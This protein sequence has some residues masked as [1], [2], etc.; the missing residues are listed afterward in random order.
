VETEEAA[1]AA[2][3]PAARR[4]A[5]GLLWGAAQAVLLC[6]PLLAGGLAA[7]YLTQALTGRPASSTAA[8]IGA[9]AGAGAGVLVCHKARAWLLEARLRRLRADGVSARGVVRRL[10][11]QWSAGGRGGSMT[12]YAAH[13]QWRDPATGERWQGERR[14]RFYGRGSRQLEAVLAAGEQVELRYPAGRPQRFVIDVPF[15]PVMA[16]VLG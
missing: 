12:R 14:Y 6:G 8:L 5:I 2:I 9:A 15:A 13:V 1:H 11:R 10:D 16:D 7:A 3:V 4:L